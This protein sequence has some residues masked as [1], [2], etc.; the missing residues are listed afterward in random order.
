MLC[1]AVI[2]AIYLIRRDNHELQKILYIYIYNF[3]YVY[4]FLHC[5]K[6]KMVITPTWARSL[7]VFCGCSLDL[8]PGEGGNAIPTTH[9]AHGSL[10]DVTVAGPGAATAGD[11]DRTP[12]SAPGKD[13]AAWCYRQ[14]RAAGLFPRQEKIKKKHSSFPFLLKEKPQTSPYSQEL[15]FSF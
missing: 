13:E 1:S 2:Q 15:P 9:G 6:R 8:L 3:I 7:Q 4:H 12:A 10:A 11:C 14:K 5:K